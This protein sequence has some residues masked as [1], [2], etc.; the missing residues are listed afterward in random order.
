MIETK[1]WSERTAAAVLLALRSLCLEVKDFAIVLFSMYT[2]EIK[3][4]LA[5]I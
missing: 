4:I 1:N 3:F 5:T 2:N